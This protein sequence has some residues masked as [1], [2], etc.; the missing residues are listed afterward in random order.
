MTYV[1]HEGHAGREKL[2]ILR[3]ECKVMIERAE[4][5]IRVSPWICNLGQALQLPGHQ[6]PHL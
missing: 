5:R 2:Q 6:C 4:I 1:E 3:K